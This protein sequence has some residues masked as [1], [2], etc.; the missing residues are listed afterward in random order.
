M[1]MHRVNLI[2]RSDELNIVV[3]L[4]AMYT[5]SNGYCHV[6]E[7]NRLQGLRN[8]KDMVVSE[9]E[10]GCKIYEISWIWSCQRVKQGA[11]FMEFH[12]YGRVRE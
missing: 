5:E 1:V 3:Q 2:A 11:R 10:T 12:G 7:L 8:Y 4:A 9:S 6:G